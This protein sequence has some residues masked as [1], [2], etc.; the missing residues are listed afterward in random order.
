M[1]SHQLLT[2]NQKSLLQV[3]LI[4]AVIAVMYS[5]YTSEVRQQNPQAQTRVC[6]SFF[7]TALQ[8]AL[9]SGVTDLSE[10][11]KAGLCRDIQ[12]CTYLGQNLC[13]PFEL[14]S[15]LRSTV[16]VG[17]SPISPSLE[18]ENPFSASVNAPVASESD[19]VFS[20]ALTSKELLTFIQ[21]SR[22][23]RAIRSVLSDAILQAR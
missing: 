18:S 22:A 10:N 23:T 4:V 19:V 11:R 8:R 21:I 5:I 7:N 15:E 14:G 3:I 1:L 2:M 20:P 9:A 6:Q 13:A 12:G 16:S 17:G